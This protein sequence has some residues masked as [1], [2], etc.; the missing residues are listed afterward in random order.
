MVI[1]RSLP[2]LHMNITEVLFR[3]SSGV[4]AEVRLVFLS[5]EADGALEFIFRP[6]YDN[7]CAP[8]ARQELFTC[9]YGK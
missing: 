4:G 2:E 6:V 1:H 8:G 9:A 7:L 3:R 5:S